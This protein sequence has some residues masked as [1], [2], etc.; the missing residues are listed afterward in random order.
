MMTKIG[1]ND[2]CP[3]GSGQKYKKCCLDSPQ[4][5][6]Q[7]E[8]GYTYAYL[9]ID[10]LSNSI[11]GLLRKRDFEGAKAVCRQLLNEYPDQIDG[12]S[13]YAQ[14]YEAIGD[15]K[16]AAEYFHKAA[17]FATVNED[18]DQES[19]DMYLEDAKRMELDG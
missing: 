4:K 2:S 16:K 6:P 19:V 3:C 18:F 13:R 10:K 12:I 15:R 5:L 17:E 11:N 1:R 7:V 8:P 14:V 9:P